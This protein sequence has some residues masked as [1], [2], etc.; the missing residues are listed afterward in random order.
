MPMT[1]YRRTLPLF[2]PTLTTGDFSWLLTGEKIMARK[3]S[4]RYFESRGAYYTQLNGKQCL[5]ARGEDDYPNGPTYQA[6]LDEFTN[7]LKGVAQEDAG[8]SMP[9]KFVADRYVQNLIDTGKKPKTVKLRKEYLQ[10]FL[11]HV[12]ELPANAVTNDTITEWFKTEK[13]WGESVRYMA[14]TSVRAALTYGKDAKLLS[15]K[16]DNLRFKGLN[17]NPESKGK[18]SVIT[19]DQ[20]ERIQ[21]DTKKKAPWLLDVLHFMWDCGCRPGEG[22]VI[23]AAMVNWSISAVI[24]PAKLTK[25]PKKGD[26]VIALAT[27]RMVEIVRRKCEQ[28]PKGPLF[29]GQREILTEELLAKVFSGI[30]KRVGFPVT[31]YYFRH[32]FATNFLMHGGKDGTPGSIAVLAKLLGNSVRMIEKHYGHLEFYRSNLGDIVRAFRGDSGTKR[33]R[34]LAAVQGA[35]DDQIDAIAALLGVK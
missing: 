1:R 5:L 32:T 29:R 14:A 4:I 15:A 34:V 10:G 21:E 26:R 20:W 30:S 22:T 2:F 7:L 35:N 11:D 24:I 28:F 19:A 23:T 33:Q 8:D 25:T 3:S 13:K 31:A 18:E 6:A 9:F 27:P 12:G 16:V 17:I